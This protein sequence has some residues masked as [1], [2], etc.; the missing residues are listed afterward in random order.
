MPAASDG[1]CASPYFI[2]FYWCLWGNRQDSINT[3]ISN[4]AVG[5]V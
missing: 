4:R 1:Q 3:L 5:F 2:S